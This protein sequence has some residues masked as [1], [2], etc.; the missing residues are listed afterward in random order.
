M[1]IFKNPDIFREGSTFFALFSW[2]VLYDFTK[3][4]ESET[5]DVL[6]T[7]NQCLGNDKYILKGTTNIHYQHLS[8]K[9]ESTKSLTF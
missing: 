7:V 2:R 9:G 6:A 3:I 5:A 1:T 4:G 8:D